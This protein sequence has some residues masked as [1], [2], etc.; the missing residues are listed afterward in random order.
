MAKIFSDSKQI[1][2]AGGI[3][4]RICPATNNLPTKMSRAAWDRTCK[5]TQ[6]A[7]SVW[8]GAG[9]SKD[10]ENVSKRLNY[11]LEC[12]GTILPP[13]LELIDLTEEKNVATTTRKGNCE[14]CGAKGLMVSKSYKAIDQMICSN[15]AGI[16]ANVNQRPEVVV[17]AAKNLGKEQVFIDLLMPERVEF[18]PE[19]ETLRQIAKIVGYDGQDAAGVV[20][21]LE[22]GLGSLN[23]AL[24][25]AMASV[26]ELR[27]HEQWRKVMLSRAEHHGKREGESFAGWLDSVVEQAKMEI[28]SRAKAHELEEQVA[29]LRAE[30]ETLLFV[31]PV[32]TEELI[33]HEAYG[34]YS[35]SMERQ[36]LADFGLRVLQGK[37]RLEVAA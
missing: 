15:C 16:H 5:A 28:V 19:S 14:C 34:E 6:K 26:G 24:D 3:R 12:Q 20:K 29:T 10:V 1:R 32:T 31:A 37:V 13:G 8:G 30:V 9:Y 2:D 27:S 7:Q 17:R 18:E 36:A 33:G 35:L 4:A 25:R 23:Q 22:E 11:C 21:A